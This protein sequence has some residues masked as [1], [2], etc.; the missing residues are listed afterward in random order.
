MVIQSRPLKREEILRLAV[1]A[2]LMIEE[3]DTF[4]LNDLVAEKELLVFARLLETRL[5]QSLGGML[6]G[7]E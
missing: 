1:Q 3:G 6:V 7:G 4:C 2:R 5:N